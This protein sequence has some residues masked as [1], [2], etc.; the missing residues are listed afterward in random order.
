MFC[1]KYV[2]L[3]FKLKTSP[4]WSFCPWWCSEELT[5]GPGGGGEKEKKKNH[6]PAWCSHNYCKFTRMWQDKENL[7]AC[8]VPCQT[9]MR[10]ITASW[11]CDRAETRYWTTS[12]PAGR[13]HKQM[14]GVSLKGTRVNILISESNLLLVVKDGSRRLFWWT[15]NLPGNFPDES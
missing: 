15:G 8:T 11:S 7:L 6:T 1:T 9:S 10:A 2:Q 13:P 4:I 12:G 5:A 14:W 3:S